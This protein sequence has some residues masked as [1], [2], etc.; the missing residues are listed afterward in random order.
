[1]DPS[2]ESVLFSKSSLS[3]SYNFFMFELFFFLK[4]EGIGFFGGS[5]KISTEQD[6][7]VTAKSKVLV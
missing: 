4:L 3:T 1:V 5:D 2:Q 7:G 6:R